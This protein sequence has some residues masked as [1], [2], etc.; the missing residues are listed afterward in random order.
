VEPTPAGPNLA[1]GCTTAGLAERLEKN[2][3]RG[4]EVLSGLVP[5]AVF[6]TVGSYVKRAVGGFDSHALPPFRAHSNSNFTSPSISFK[7]A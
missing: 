7:R 6:K 1:R 4:V 2:R 3:K 5:L